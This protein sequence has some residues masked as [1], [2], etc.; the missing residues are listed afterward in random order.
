M[1]NP[2]AH[3]KVHGGIPL[4]SEQKHADSIEI[5][6]KFIQKGTVGKIGVTESKY[7]ILGN[8]NAFGGSVAATPEDLF[9]LTKTM[10]NTKIAQQE[11]RNAINSYVRLEKAKRMEKDLAK[12]LTTLKQQAAE[13][14]REL[15][16]LRGT[17]GGSR[18]QF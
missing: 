9:Q 2:N 3:G 1:L 13:K 6:N 10:H 5:A 18:G 7:D 16:Y 4:F 17:Y 14:E 8:K 15:E 12:Q 11:E